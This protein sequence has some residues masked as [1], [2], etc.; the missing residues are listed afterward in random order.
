MSAPTKPES[1]VQ[2]NAPTSRRDFLRVT[3]LAG[4]GSVDLKRAAATAI[5]NILGRGAN[6]GDAVAALRTALEGATDA[7]LRIDLG[8]ALG[9]AKL[10]PE[11]TLELLQKFTRVATA[12]KSEG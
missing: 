7:G 1:G 9:K 8:A 10:A 5:G 3:A 11:A 2:L 4:G 6:G 12:P